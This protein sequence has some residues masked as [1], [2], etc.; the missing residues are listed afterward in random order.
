MFGLTVWILHFLDISS[1][2]ILEL[3]KEYEIY[4]GVISI[5]DNWG[6]CNVFLQIQSLVPD[7]NFVNAIHP[8]VVIGNNVTL[9]KGI[10]AMAGCI[11]NP[12]SIIGDF[13]FFATGEKINGM[14]HCAH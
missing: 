10:V 2:R 5:G 7:F 13:T 12:K 4:G 9:G 8:S 6:R 14:W 11:F 1:S 3:V